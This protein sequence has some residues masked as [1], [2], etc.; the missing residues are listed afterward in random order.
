MAIESIDDLVNA[1]ANNRQK[2]PIGEVAGL[3]SMIAGQRG[4]YWH[5]A[6]EPRAGVFAPSTG[7]ICD[8]TTRGAIRFENPTSGMK[9]YLAKVALMSSAVQSFEVHDRLAHAGTLSGTVTT[10][11]TISIDLHA[12]LATSNLANR[13]GAVDYSDVKWWIEHKTATGSTSRT[14]SVSYTDHEGNSGQTTAVV[15]PATQ[16]A[17]RMLPII[18]L[19]G[20]NIR[21]IQ[22]VQLN[23]STGTAGEFAVVAT[24]PLL[25]LQSPV[26]NQ[27]AI[28]DWTDNKLLEIPDSSCLFLVAVCTTTTAGIPSGAMTFIQG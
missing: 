24:V 20:D 1:M 11:Q 6:G 8:N 15:F 17:N 26:A 13:I 3:T 23:G 5:I 22:S 21:S 4:S 9:T 7:A 28:Y 27:Y 10:A 14:L 2:L 25:F 19:P 16:A 18:P 12:S